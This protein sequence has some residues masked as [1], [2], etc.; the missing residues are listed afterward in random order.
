MLSRRLRSELTD[1]GFRHRLVAAPN[2]YA[3]RV[4][5][6]AH[7][8]IGIDDPQR[9]LMRDL[10]PGTPQLDGRIFSAMRDMRA[11][12]FRIGTATVINCM[13]MDAEM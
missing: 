2:P 9:L 13:M 6:N 7:D 11:G 12:R 3:A 5:A 8:E 10:I 1:L 4:L